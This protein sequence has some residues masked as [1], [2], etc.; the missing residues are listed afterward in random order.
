MFTTLLNSFAIILSLNT[1]TG[2][3]VHETKVDKA[4]VT[5]L[6]PPLL[7]DSFDVSTKSASIQS[8]L[9]THVERTSIAQAL[10]NERSEAPSTRPRAFD[11]K[12]YLLPKNVVRGHHAFD[13]YNLPL[14]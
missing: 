1:A 10:S 6:A 11:D 9:H 8:E 7:V 3:L 4:T 14:A 5:V 2:V 13:S 12:K